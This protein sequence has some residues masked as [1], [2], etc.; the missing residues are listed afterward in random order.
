MIIYL[1][2]IKGYFHPL[3]TEYVC[4]VIYALENYVFQTAYI[5]IKRYKF[6]NK[7]LGLG[8]AF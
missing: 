1:V 2:K 8:D 4:P 3:K 7:L 5:I 6:T